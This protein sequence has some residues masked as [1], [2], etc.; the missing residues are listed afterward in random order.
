M[1]NEKA[2]QNLL[3]AEFTEFNDFDVTLE[4]TDNYE[5]FCEVWAYS[6][7]DPAIND[8]CVTV[9]GDYDGAE[10]VAEAITLTIYRRIAQIRKAVS[11]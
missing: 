8:L 2:I 6:E 3:A 9:Q 7:T 11:K 5:T 1:T 4:E 10:E